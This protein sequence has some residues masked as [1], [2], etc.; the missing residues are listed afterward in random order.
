MGAGKDYLINNSSLRGYSL[1]ADDI[2]LQI[3]SPVLTVESG[4]QVSPK[5]DKEVWEI[6]FNLLERRLKNQETTVINACHSKSSDFAKYKN[7]IEKYR[8]R[9]FG[10]DLRGVPIE[11][12]KAQNK[13]RDKFKIVPE[14]VIDM[15]YSRFEHQ[16][17]PNYVEIIKPGEI[18]KK[19]IYSPLDFNKYKQIFVF[20]DIHS[21]WEPLKEFFEK[22]PESDENYYVFTGDYFDRNNQAAEVLKFLTEHY[23]KSNFAFIKGNHE[24]GFQEYA[25]NESIEGI[26]SNEFIYNTV[27]QIKS[28]GFGL[29]R[30][31][32]RKF[33]NFVYFTYGGKDYFC[34]HGGIPFLPEKLGLLSYRDLIFGVG[35]Y[36][37]D[38]KIVEQ[39]NK[40]TKSNEF[41]LHGHRN[42]S[43]LPVI[44]DKVINLEGK[45]EFGGT[46]RVL[47]ITPEGMFP[48]EIKNTHFTKISVFEKNNT[49]PKEILSKNI[50]EFIE[51]KLKNNKD[52]YEVKNHHI[53]SF[54]FKKDVFYKDNW[55]K[56]KEL[57]RG[58]FINN[59]TM[60]VYGRGYQKS[61]NYCEKPETRPEFLKDNLIFPV[62][63]TRK[64]N[65][66][67][68]I[69]CYDKYKNE[70]MFCSKSR[71]DGDFARLFE[72]TFRDKYNDSLQPLVNFL[73]ENNLCA[74]FEA[75]EPNIDPHIIKYAAA[76]CVLLDLFYNDLG[77]AKINNEILIK[78]AAEFGVNCKK[79]LF[80]A[81][82]WE[83]LKKQ[84]EI[85]EN[86]T[87][88][89]ELNN[90][91]NFEGVVIEDAAGFCYKHKTYYYRFYKMFRS[92]KDNLAKGRGVK[93]GCLNT[94]EHNNFYGFLKNKPREELI[95]KQ[96]IQLRDE[97]LLTSS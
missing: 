11:V 21:S 63:G 57:P 68:G 27:P 29:L 62:V 42:L 80:T 76:D 39:W 28:A 4:F 41:L 96:I 30:N 8:Y 64:E 65:G 48:I 56:T 84:I 15:V 73:K 75:I 36:E 22:Y 37:D 91:V 32:V 95:K 86:P 40:N 79:V 59:Q 44:N 10:I 6:L 19:L 85:L 78:K 67:L 45:V 94:V 47:Q 24:K 92:I 70:P 87:F 53:S 69:L 1:S 9:L 58:F 90:G 88:D 34:C 61:F 38:A 77:T 52:V 93:L 31:I 97:F 55:N 89:A 72:K 3:Q 43:N 60:E 18:D 74:T 23:N 13:Q 35:K 26:R 81:G 12:A 49:A 5:N 17:V 51:T 46:L 2:R 16:S 83:E 82:N 14:P 54:C 71:N 33:C 50:Q 66:F 25:Y 7:L 20:G